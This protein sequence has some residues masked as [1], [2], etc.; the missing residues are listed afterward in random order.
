MSEVIASSLELALNYVANICLAVVFWIP[1]SLCVCHGKFPIWWNCLE[2]T[3]QFLML[4]TELVSINGF[5]IFIVFIFRGHLQLIF[6]SLH[7]FSS[8]CRWAIVY[9]AQMKPLIVPILSEGE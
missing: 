8:W 4:L 7:I 1:I 2:L 5:C 3:I 9:L 6:T